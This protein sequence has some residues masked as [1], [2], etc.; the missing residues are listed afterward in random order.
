MKILKKKIKLIY[1]P[2]CWSKLFTAFYWS[3]TTLNPI[4]I[5]CTVNKHWDIIQIIFCG[6]FFTY[7]AQLALPRLIKKKTELHWALH[8]FLYTW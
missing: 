5:Y 3:K 1:S 7:V 8:E 2:S 6:S 4:N